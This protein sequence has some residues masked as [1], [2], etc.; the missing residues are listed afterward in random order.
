MKIIIGLII[1]FTAAVYETYPMSSRELEVKNKY[2]LHKAIEEGN[3]NEIKQL[4][5]Q[6]SEP[7]E[8]NDEGFTALNYA[9]IY[10]VNEKIIELLV[11]KQSVVQ[12]EWRLAMENK[13][14]TFIHQ[15]QYYYIKDMWIKYRAELLTVLYCENAKNHTF[16]HLVIVN[17]DEEMFNRLLLDNKIN[18]NMKN[19]FGITP[20]HLAAF[21]NNI[22]MLRLLL[23]KARVD[24]N[25][26]SK[27][28]CT[29][30]HFS[31][32]NDNVQ[33]A[34]I[35]LEMGI[36]AKIKNSFGKKAKELASTEEM[37]QVFLSEKKKN[38]SCIIL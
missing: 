24:I 8:E 3:Y 26:Q 29:A 38:S 21:D 9:V 32:A 12:K 2:P 18:F 7:L 35:L 23:L 4:I 11:D 20:L 5:M 16:L 1:F 34:K 15:K 22:K 27:N 25:A 6:G 13:D 17:S 36:N 30:L 37:R 28:N 19:R 14:E 31:I 33:A 10:N